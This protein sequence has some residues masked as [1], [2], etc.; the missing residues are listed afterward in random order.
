MGFLFLMK[1][2]LSRNIVF[3]PPAQK[4]SAVIGENFN[5]IKGYVKQLMYLL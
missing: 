1:S 3:T 2:S 5:F 4:R